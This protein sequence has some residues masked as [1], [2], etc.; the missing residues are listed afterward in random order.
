METVAINFHDKS[1]LMDQVVL[2]GGS[3]AKDARWIRFGDPDSKLYASHG[4][5]I[6]LL[7]RRHNLDAK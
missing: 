2:K 7:A 1:G 3:D 6:A 5:L 4:R